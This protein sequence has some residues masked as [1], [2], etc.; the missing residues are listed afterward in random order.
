MILNYLERLKGLKKWQLNF[1]HQC[2]YKENFES[3]ESCFVDIPWYSNSLSFEATT[4]SLTLSELFPASFSCS[5]TFSLS[6]SSL[7]RKM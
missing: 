6:H 5:K 1:W 7:R 3:R 4:F 2:F